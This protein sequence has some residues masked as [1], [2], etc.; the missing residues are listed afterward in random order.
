MKPTPQLRRSQALTILRS[1]LIPNEPFTADLLYDA[2]LN[3]GFTNNEAGRLVGSLV[4]IASS[5]GW[6]RKS[7]NWVQSR[8]NR[9]N[10][11]IIWIT[12]KNLK[13]IQIK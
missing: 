5:K 4:R 2:L 10:I 6:I 9:S 11:Q 1:E 8:R 3:K 12:S 7:E 13:D